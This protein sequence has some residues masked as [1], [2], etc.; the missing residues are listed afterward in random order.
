M[1]PPPILIA[2]Q[3]INSAS[4]ELQIYAD[5]LQDIRYLDPNMDMRNRLLAEALRQQ[6]AALDA[7]HG[8]LLRLTEAAMED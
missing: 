4:C 3:S 7:I 8:R 5:S 2:I 1:T 6:V